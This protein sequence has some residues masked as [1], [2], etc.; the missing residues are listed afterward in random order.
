MIK[1]RKARR[2]FI[3]VLKVILAG[4]KQG[5]KLMATFNGRMNA[6]MLKAAITKEWL[7]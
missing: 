4:K 2:R 7:G 1:E 6:D 5:K 3:G